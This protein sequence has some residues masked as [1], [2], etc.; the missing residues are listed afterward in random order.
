M[1]LINTKT[2][3]ELKTG[4][5]VR[6]NKGAVYVLTGGAPPHKPSSTGKVWLR[7]IDGKGMDQ[8][9]FPSVINA[10]WV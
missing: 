6:T 7:T 8:E 3:Q 10:E 5:I 1:K 4:E 9:F 2:K